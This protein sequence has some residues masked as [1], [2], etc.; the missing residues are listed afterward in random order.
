MGWQLVEQLSNAVLFA[1][2]VH[3]RHFILGYLRKVKMNLNSKREKGR[4][5]AEIK[6]WES[7]ELCESFLWYFFTVL[8]ADFFFFSKLVWGNI[9]GTVIRSC[10]ASLCCPPK[11][12][13]NQIIFYIQIMPNDSWGVFLVTAIQIYASIGK[14]WFR[15]HNFRVCLRVAWQCHSRRGIV[16]IA[17]M[18]FGK[19]GNIV[20]RPKRVAMTTADGGCDDSAI[21]LTTKIAICAMTT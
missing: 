12:A 1:G 18:A 8:C 13:A 21:N 16:C 4:E 3:V 5:G 15:R 2:T 11:I 17:R 7:H 14:W 9:F 10:R 20:W 6:V 19:T